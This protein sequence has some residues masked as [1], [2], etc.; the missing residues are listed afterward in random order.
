LADPI[1]IY[2]DSCA[3]IG[4][5]NAEPSKI[6]LLRSVWE[7][8]QRGKYEIWTSTY[9]YV[10]LY[11]GLTSYGHAY[12]PEESDVKFEELLDQPYVKRFQLSVPVGKRA[13]KL[14]R[15]LHG[16]G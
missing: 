13:R 9:A 8:A 11:F 7:D 14:K 16:Q 4:L 5:V 6:F 3:W 12:P 2:W 15:D 10:E 1:R